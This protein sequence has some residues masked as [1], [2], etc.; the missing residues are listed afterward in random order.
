MNYHGGPTFGPESYKAFAALSPSAR[1]AVQALNPGFKPIQVQEA[2]SP[3]YYSAEDEFILELDGYFDPDAATAITSSLLS[4]RQQRRSAAGLSGRGSKKGTL[5]HGLLALA[6][7]VWQA[8]RLSVVVRRAGAVALPALGAATVF[9]WIDD[10]IYDLPFFS[11]DDN[12]EGVAVMAK[13]IEQ[14]V[15]DGSIRPAVIRRGYDDDDGTADI[16]VIKDLNKL[17]PTMYFTHRIFGSGYVK[18]MRTNLQNESD[19]KSAR[20]KR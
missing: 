9:D 3:T 10:N 2:E 15:M 8:A 13:A 19:R 20:K 1:S 14:A 4:Q 17:Q 11:E 16:L 18:A 7:M 12:L 6:L 5:M